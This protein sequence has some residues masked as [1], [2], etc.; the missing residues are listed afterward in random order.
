MN[1]RRELYIHFDRKKLLKKKFPEWS[2]WNPEN[3]GK[4]VF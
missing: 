1:P 3:F 2:S 4:R